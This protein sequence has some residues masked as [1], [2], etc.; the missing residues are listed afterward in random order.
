VRSGTL[1]VYADLFNVYDRR[2]RGSYQYALQYHGDLLVETVRT[3][4]GEELI[5]FLPM[6]GLRYRF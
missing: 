2:N 1:E 6:V 4:G 3:D 5:P